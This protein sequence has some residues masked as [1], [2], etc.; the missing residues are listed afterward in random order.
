MPRLFIAIDIP[1][2]I[3]DDISA[4][5]IAIPGARW[6]EDAQIH[7]TLRFIGEV[8]NPVEQE[9][10]VA[11]K[12]VSMP[13]FNL[14]LKSVG[15]FPPRKEPRILWVGIN[16][17]PELIRLQSKIEH[18]LTASGIQPDTRHFHAHITVARLDNT[19]VDKAALYLTNNS[20]FSTEPFEVSDFHLYESHLKK[21]GA[22][23]LKIATFKM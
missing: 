1:D 3:K 19:P 10:I 5:Y 6:I 14:T 18:A 20:L 7:L 16:D 22:L 9:I 2:R 12:N 15:F 11:L 13:S 21:E 8:D 4:T 17:S 23:H